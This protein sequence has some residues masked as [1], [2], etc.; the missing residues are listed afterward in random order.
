MNAKRL[1]SGTLALVAL[2]IAAL[3]PS[4]SADSRTCGILPGDGAF[5]YVKA[6]DV[7][8]RKAR[9]IGNKAGRRF[10]RAGGCNALP[11]EKPSKGRVRVGAWTCK[12]KVGWEAYQARCRNGDKS[13]LQRSGA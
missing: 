1:I 5:N 6:H 3:A 11:N 13:F 12:M 9:Q 4:A 2:A 7:S 10:C 8:C